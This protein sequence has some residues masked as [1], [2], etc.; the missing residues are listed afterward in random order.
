[1]ATASQS[2]RAHTLRLYI[3]GGWAAAD[4][5]RTYEVLNPATEEVI[6]HAPDATRGDLEKACVH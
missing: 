6:A 5:G 1:M 3:D 4:G 2:S